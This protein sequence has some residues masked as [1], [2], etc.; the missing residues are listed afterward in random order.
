MRHCCRMFARGGIIMTLGCVAVATA[1]DPPSDPITFESPTGNIRCEIAPH[2]DAAAARCVTLAPRR[3]A[4]VIAGQKARVVAFA[5]IG[6]LTKSD[7]LR[8]GESVK[9]FGFRCRS[10]KVG[11]TCRDTQT[12][13]GFLIAKEGVTLLPRR[14]KPAPRPS[15]PARGDRYNCDDFPL[16]DGTTAQQYLD[17]DPSDP[18]QLD[19]DRDGIACQGG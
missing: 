9:G 12:G 5:A 8:Y 6:S 2:A 14:A 1:Q 17:Q 11:V 4:R 10:Q 18:S 16:P 19:G 3:A 7:V 15:R 13:N